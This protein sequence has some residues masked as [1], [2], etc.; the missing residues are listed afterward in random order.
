MA[1]MLTAA[2]CPSFNVAAAAKF[3]ALAQHRTGTTFMGPKL[4]GSQQSRRLVNWFA[5]EVG[6]ELEMQVMPI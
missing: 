5:Y 3:S 4:H 1:L 6:I 2:I